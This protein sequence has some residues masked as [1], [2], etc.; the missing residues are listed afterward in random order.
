MLARLLFPP[1]LF[2][3]IFEDAAFG[4]LWI[5]RGLWEKGDVR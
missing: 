4:R 3:V 2:S 5:E 1:L